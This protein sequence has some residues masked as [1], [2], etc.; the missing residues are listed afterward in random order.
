MVCEDHFGRVYGP[1]AAP[2]LGQ[3]MDLLEK[4][5]VILDLDFL[6]L[7]FPVLGI[8][9]QSLEAEAPMPEG[10]FHVQTEPV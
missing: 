8:A 6:S 4:V 1:G 9:L 2:A 3:A 7:F 10:L 5:T